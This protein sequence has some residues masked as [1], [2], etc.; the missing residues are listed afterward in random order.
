MHDRFSWQGKH[1]MTILAA[2]PE[3]LCKLCDDARDNLDLNVHGCLITSDQIQVL[4]QMQL[5]PAH[6]LAASR[7]RIG[8]YVSESMRCLLNFGKS[9]LPSRA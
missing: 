8:T 5:E 3:L 9:D 1:G 2:D 7:C 6:Q 4:S